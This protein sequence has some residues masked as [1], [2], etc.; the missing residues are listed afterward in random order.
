MDWHECVMSIANWRNISSSWDRSPSTTKELSVRSIQAALRVRNT[1]PPLC[2]ELVL[3]FIEILILM[4]SLYCP[5]DLCKS[6]VIVY[7]IGSYVGSYGWLGVQSWRIS[8]VFLLRLVIYVW[9]NNLNTITIL[10]LMCL[11]RDLWHRVFI[12]IQKTQVYL[13]FHYM[14]YL[15]RRQDKSSW[16]RFYCVFKSDSAKQ[17]GLC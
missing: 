17:W 16:G 3:I 8:S 2:W 7:P 4:S 5:I 10:M 12:Q 1:P 6:F 9:I 11:S 15:K 13:D 14:S